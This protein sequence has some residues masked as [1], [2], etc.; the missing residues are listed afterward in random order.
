MSS[1][2][3]VYRF[4]DHYPERFRT[5]ASVFPSNVCDFLEAGAFA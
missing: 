1:S 5:T 4:F 3:L 2:M